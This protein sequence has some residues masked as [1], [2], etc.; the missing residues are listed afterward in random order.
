[1]AA[2]FAKK[3]AANFDFLPLD[4]AAGELERQGAIFS[5]E[6]SKLET[7]R[8]I[9]KLK[10]VLRTILGIHAG[11]LRSKSKLSS[12][13]SALETLKFA[14]CQLSPPAPQELWDWFDFSHSITVAQIILRSCLEREET[15]GAHYR[16]D[17]PQMDDENW[18]V[19]ICINKSSLGKMT[20]SRS[21]VLCCQ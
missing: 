18:L 6:R 1:M 2:I 10:K 15:R 4:Y 17:F 7:V 21:T 11:V 8:E 3:C 16:Q 13:L 20:I 12:G 9:S 19:N 14:F 5:G